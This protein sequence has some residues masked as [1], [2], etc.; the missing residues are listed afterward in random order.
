M[1]IVVIGVGGVVAHVLSLVIA[2][3]SQWL[4]A[5]VTRGAEEGYPFVEDLRQFV[6]WLLRGLAGQLCDRRGYA[7][8]REYG[9]WEPEYV[10]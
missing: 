6:R 1:K 10:R 4:L 7:A 8:S 2:H 9:D 5:K 3:Y